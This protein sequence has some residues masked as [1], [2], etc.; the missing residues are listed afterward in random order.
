MLAWVMT[1]AKEGSGL[2]GSKGDR[3][4]QAEQRLGQAAVWD[5]ATVSAVE[6]QLAAAAAW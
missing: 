6:P 5:A 2:R 4:G 1:A 3:A